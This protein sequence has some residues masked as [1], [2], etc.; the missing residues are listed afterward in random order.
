CAVCDEPLSPEKRRP[1]ASSLTGLT[2]GV[3]RPPL[4]S[5]TLVGERY[6]ITVGGECGVSGWVLRAQDTQEDSEVA[7]KLIHS[8]LLQT[9]DER[10]GFL[11]AIKRTERLQ[12]P[13]VAR[14]IAGG[15]DGAQLFYTMSYFEGLT[16]RKIIDLRLEKEQLFKLD[17][18]L[19]LF[20]QL[21]VALDHLAKGG[22]HGALRPSNIIVLP[23]VLKVTG[24]A[25]VQGLPRRPYMMLLHERG[26][27][28]YVAPEVRHGDGKVIVTADIY[29]MAVIVAE[30]IT[31]Q[32]Y[33]RDAA[34]WEDVRQDV[35]SRLAAVLQRALSDDA[36]ER[37]SSAS[38]FYTELA[39]AAAS[40]GVVVGVKPTP[41]L[42]EQEATVV[43]ANMPPV[44][45][46]ESSPRPQHFPAAMSEPN[47][48]LATMRPATPIV[49]EPSRRARTLRVRRRLGGGASS[50]IVVIAV[51]IVLAGLGI[52]AALWWQGRPRFVNAPTPRT[53]LVP[54]VGGRA[55]VILRPRAVGPEQPSV[56]AADAVDR[57]PRARAERPVDAGPS[58]SALLQARRRAARAAQGLGDGRR[59][60]EEPALVAAPPPPPPPVVPVRPDPPPATELPAAD[61]PTGACP[62]GMSYIADGSFL[63]GS[64]SDDPLRGFGELPAMRKHVDAFCIDRFE[65]P[66]VAGKVTVSGMSWED[67]ERACDG[68]GRRLCTEMEWE[69]ACKGRQGRA[70]PY[71]NE[72]RAG[73]CNLG[74][75]APKR[76]SGSL[77][78]CRSQFGVLDLAGNVAEWTASQFPGSIA[79]K[80]VKGGAAGQPDFTGRC[81]ARANE[82]SRSAQPTIGYRCCADMD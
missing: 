11:K 7:L 56:R 28:D 19:P 79:G 27:A 23:D 77:R 16:L 15:R 73:A 20:G 64:T 10:A 1:P 8:N 4:K 18:V 32:R 74:E 5:G 81:A 47:I 33:G 66:N 53:T 26:E 67:A 52:S 9:E 78:D 2:T 63:M 42:L 61:E 57:R 3:T 34:A 17:E 55:R 6:R 41:T 30:M 36:N 43:E 37:F 65:A 50:R 44:S 22:S 38:T 24:I 46:E 13:N 39:A 62:A 48:E 76:A 29:S 71:G 80:V 49:S 45:P 75:G 58:S 12:H 14:I 54:P 25:H 51:A 59:G 68:A 35:P 70:F 31:G 72:V 40:R 82:S 60:D 21:A 69:Y